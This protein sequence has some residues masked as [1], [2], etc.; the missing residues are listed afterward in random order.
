MILGYARVSTDEQNLDAQTD[1]LT[2]AG[3]GRIF[4]DKISG[5]TR[6]RPNLAAIIDHARE[7]DVIVVTKY[8]RLAR[9]LHDLLEIVEA[10]KVIPALP[11]FLERHPRIDVAF[12]QSERIVDLVREGVDCAIRVGDPV[13]D[14]LMMRRLG[15]L[16]EVTVASPDYLRR[17]GTPQTVDDLGGHAMIGFISS[18]TGDVMPL[19]FTVGEDVHQQRLPYRVSANDAETAADLVTLGYGLYQAP[20]YRFAEALRAGTLVEMMGSYAPPPTSV[21]ALYART[22]QPTPRLRAFLDWASAIFAEELPRL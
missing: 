7:G 12:G 21:S 4:A 3:A 14:S 16:Q 19:E 18:R 2:A 11:A 10:I 17:H 9:S 15:A 6:S 5:T 8:D 1:A 20:F 22:R 13:D